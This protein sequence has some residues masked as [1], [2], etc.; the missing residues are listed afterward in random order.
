MPVRGTESAVLELRWYQR[1]LGLV[2]LCGFAIAQPLLAT[3][4]TSPDTFIFRD[5]SSTDVVI[6]AFAIA[7]V[8][9]LAL[10]GL[11]AVCGLAGSRAIRTVH[12][13]LVGLLL[14]LVGV[15]AL[16]QVASLRGIAVV[17]GG[18]ATGI[19][20]VAIYRRADTARV[21]LRISACAPALFVGL[22]LFSSSV[23]PLVT[24]DAGGTATGPTGRAPSTVLVVFDEWPTT[25]IVDTDGRIDRD[26]YP[27]LAAFADTATWY[28][29]ASSISNSTRYA[30]PAILT[31]RLQHSDRL[32]VASS[33]PQNLFSLFAPTH[34][35][36]AFES[37]T[38][39]CP[40]SQCGA[41]TI[42]GQA[43]ITGLLGDA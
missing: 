2:A 10:W 9:P 19:G 24:D 8:P 28:R 40:R 12:L 41:A 13:A 17:L 5:A 32:P 14:A 37:V 36:E 43:G 38:G 18:V 23:A 26:L 35:L 6:F 25:S 11:E 7:V 27:N 31:G 33:Q 3:S 20:G 22:F 30:V 39:L 42:A 29:N 4:G 15:Q 34:R 21:F 1:L 16:K